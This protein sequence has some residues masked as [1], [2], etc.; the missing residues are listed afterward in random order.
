MRGCAVSSRFAHSRCCGGHR[1]L[2]RLDKR[3]VAGVGVQ[4]LGPWL[5]DATPVFV[6]Q[7]LEEESDFQV[8]KGFG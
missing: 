1:G 5:E 3:W 8:P 4:I 2:R 7:T 6:A